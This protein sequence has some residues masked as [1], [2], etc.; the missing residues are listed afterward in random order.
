MNSIANDSLPSKSG[1]V[2]GL[3]CAIGL[4]TGDVCLKMPNGAKVMMFVITVMQGNSANA[5]LVV[6]VM[7]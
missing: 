1:P 3:S 7:C 4:R 6:L 2:T 5:G